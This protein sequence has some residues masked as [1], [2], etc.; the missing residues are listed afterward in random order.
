MCYAPTEAATRE[1]KD[2]FYLQLQSVLNGVLTVDMT[3]LLGDMNAK[4]GSHE[5]G[6]EDAVGMFD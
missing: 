6:D 3:V 4:V 2:T 5:P 1:V